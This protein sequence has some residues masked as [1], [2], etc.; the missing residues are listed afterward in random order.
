MKYNSLY[1]LKVDKEY[2]TT[3]VEL[4]EQVSELL[5]NLELY[6]TDGKLI[7]SN[8]NPIKYPNFKINNLGLILEPIYYRNYQILVK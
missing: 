3:L 1:F 4:H 8:I 6:D 2:E 5:F 7:D